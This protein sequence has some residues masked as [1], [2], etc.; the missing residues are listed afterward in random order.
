MRNIK[1]KKNYTEQ[2]E[3]AVSLCYFAFLLGGA[4][5][6]WLVP[7]TPEQGVRVRALA[8]KS[9]LYSWTRHFSLTVPLSF[10]V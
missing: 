7:S 3:H 5:A 10:Q 9:V 4:V 2:I 6:L 1:I 8:G